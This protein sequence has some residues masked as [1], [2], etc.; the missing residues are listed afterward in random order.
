MRLCILLLLGCVSNIKALPIQPTVE[1]VIYGFTQDTVLVKAGETFSNRCWIENKSTQTLYLTSQQTT[2]GLLNLPDTVSLH[3]GERKFFPLKYLANSQT[4]KKAVQPIKIALQATKGGVSVQQS[5]MFYVSLIQIQG[6][7]IDTDEPEIYLN[8]L[9]DQAQFLVR[10]YNN[11]IVPID[12][13]LMLDELPE[14]LVFEGDTSMLALQPGEQKSLLFTAKN[15]L[16]HSSQADFAVTI[17]GTDAQHEVLALKRLCILRISSDR[18]LAT[19]QTPFYQN[20]PNTWAFRYLNVDQTAS[21]Y[22]FQGNGKYRVEHQQLAYQ[23]NMDYFSKGQ[24][25]L[26]V[27]D[28][29][30]AYRNKDWGIHIGAIYEYLDFNMYGNGIK[31]TAYIGEKQS[32]QIYGLENNNLLYSSFGNQSFGNTFAVAYRDEDGTQ[33]KNLVLLH[34]TDQITAVNTTLLSGKA[35]VQM[36]IDQTVQVE[37][38][39]SVVETVNSPH[40]AMS[41]VALGISYNLNKNGLNFYSHNYYATPYYGGN[42]KGVLQLDNSVWWVAGANKTWGARIVLTNNQPKILSGLDSVSLPISNRYGHT[43]YELGYGWRLGRLAMQVSPYYFV[44]HMDAPNAFGNIDHWQSKSIRSK[45]NLSYSH[46]YHEFTLVADNGYTFKNTSDYPPAPFFSSRINANYHHQIAGFMAFVQFNSYYLADALAVSSNPRYVV[47]SFGP[48]TN[49]ALAKGKI[50]VNANALY[51]YFGYNRSRNYALNSNLRW[52]LKHDWAISADIFYGLNTQRADLTYNPIVG[53]QQT[54]QNSLYEAIYRFDNKQLR[55]SVEKSF[56]Q[57]RDAGLKKLELT[58]FEDRN[59]NGQHDKEEP[60]VPGLLIKI[61][62]LTAITNDKGVVRFTALKDKNYSIS[63]VNNQGW[64]VMEAT[65]VFL[66]DNKKLEIPLVKTSRL[67]GTIHYVSDRYHAITPQLAGIKVNAQ[68]ANGKVFTT[69]TNEK[70]LFNFYLPES[71][72]TVYLDTEGMPFTVL[73]PRE[74]VE[75][76]AH[77]QTTLTFRC[78]DNSRKV[79]VTK[80]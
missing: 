80:F 26:N 16:N 1:A 36:A 38:G 7:V 9:T 34:H 28:S 15:K 57:Q 25:G 66:N 55:I 79:E 62:G 72:Y 49:F 45:I 13:K 18:R 77:E 31:A 54:V 32:I 8:Q 29:Y 75:M 24:P 44:Q 70:G 17:K 2:S 65:E 73:N 47:Y 11:A 37:A 33:G 64:S 63:M 51:N 43:L 61:D 42:R 10:C 4:I 50:V 27:Y 19:N 58:Y 21:I 59:G 52:L 23:L 22:Q 3:A 5:A 78:Q 67:M 74:N 20:K 14:G 6:L 48:N 69:V 76:H 60:Y 68:M 35:G 46:T 40:S 41:G 71:S 39:Y 12:F 53:P 56:G 30:V